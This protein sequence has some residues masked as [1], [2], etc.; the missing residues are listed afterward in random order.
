MAKKEFTLAFLADE[1]K[2]VS[3]VDWLVK[4]GDVVKE[5]DDLCEIVTDKASLVLSVPCDGRI[6][7]L[8]VKSDDRLENDT[9]LLT[10]E[11]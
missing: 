1:L 8:L 4:P 3:F 7:D 6:S 10:M 11:V 9:V 5:G 2:D